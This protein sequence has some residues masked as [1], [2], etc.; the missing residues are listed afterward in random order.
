[1]TREP[2][3]S[4]TPPDV[5]AKRESLFARQKAARRLAEESWKGFFVSLGIRTVVVIAV[6]LAI[7]LVLR[8]LVGR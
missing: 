5:D 2:T 6:V 7:F 3:N 4:E 8:L 1:V